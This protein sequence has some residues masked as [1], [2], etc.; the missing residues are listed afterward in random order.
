L[1]L[2]IKLSPSYGKL[3][4]LKTLSIFVVGKKRGYLLEELGQLNLKGELHVKNLE[5]VKIEAHAK[6][7]NMSCKHLNQLRLSWGRNEESQL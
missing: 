1:Q 4:S 2:T 3:T 6:E 5:R 7:A